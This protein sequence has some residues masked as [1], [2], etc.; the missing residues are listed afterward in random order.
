MSDFVLHDAT[1]APEASRPRLAAVAANWGFVPKLHAI[2]AESPVALGGYEALFGLIESEATLPPVE[3]QAVFL[4]VSVFHGCA[5]CTMGHTFLARQAGM[6][7]ADL[8]ALRAGRLPASPRLAAIAGFARR[9]VEARGHVGKAA[10]ADALAA[11]LTRAQVL[12][13]VAIVAAKTISNYVNHLAGTP[14]EPFMADPALAWSPATRDLAPVA[15]P[16]R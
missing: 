2:L 14:A 10:L 16:L 15:E 6:A 1:T 3:R 4:A 12:E 7:E 8:A 13:M 5:Y 11:G 9:L